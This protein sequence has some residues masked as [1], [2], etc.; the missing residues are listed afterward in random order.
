M[1][2]RAL[3]FIFSK[4][5][6]SYIGSFSYLQ[7]LIFVCF[8]FL[9]LIGAYL[10]YFFTT[11]F[12]FSLF[13]YIYNFNK[14]DFVPISIALFLAIY[15]ITI[16][17]VTNNLNKKNNII[18]AERDELKLLN[19]RYIQEIEKRKKTEKSLEI[20]EQS[21]EQSSK[22]AEIGQMSAAINH[23]ISQPLLALRT[24]LSS[25][26]MLLERNRVMEAKSNFSRVNDL[27]LRMEKITSQLRIFSTKSENS[28]NRISL[29]ESIDASL[30]MISPQ[31]IDKEIKIKY[32]PSSK[33]VFVIGD[34]IKVQQILINLL[35]NS[36]DALDGIEDAIIS[37]SFKQGQKHTKIKVVDNGKGIDAPDKIFEPF[38]TTKAQGKGVGLGLSISSDLARKFGG[39]LTAANLTPLGSEFTLTLKNG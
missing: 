30:S 3:Y 21:L 8:A 12:L 4:L 35:N 24:Y 13:Y 18:K 22:L 10:V 6:N 9:T 29:T 25:M 1:I 7:I 32:Q 38:F 23:E 33:A 39:G 17:I 36:I 5:S 20:A 28:N 34:E 27:I 15:L 19:S 11:D 14:L 31:L 2:V 16:I 26:K 37:I